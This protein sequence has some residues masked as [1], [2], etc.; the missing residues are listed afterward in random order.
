MT[1]FTEAVRHALSADSLS[2]HVNAVDAVAII[3]LIALLIEREVLR[4]HAVDF[5]HRRLPGTA[6]M[7]TPLVVLCGIFVTARMLNLLT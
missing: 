4:A 2:P 3:T 6:G 5:P 1:M 7:I